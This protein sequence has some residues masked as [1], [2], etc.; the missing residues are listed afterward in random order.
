MPQTDYHISFDVAKTVMK[1]Q[2]TEHQ[3]SNYP[4][5]NAASGCYQRPLS[6][7]V[8]LK[9][10]LPSGHNK[11][12]HLLYTNITSLWAGRCDRI[13]HSARLTPTH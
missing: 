2:F 4:K 11:M 5:H 3:I 7:Q 10:R 13:T 12:R 9:F 8:S 1:G 6:K